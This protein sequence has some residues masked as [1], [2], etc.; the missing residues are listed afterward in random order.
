VKRGLLRLHPLD[1]FLDPIEGALVC[2]RRRQALVMLDLA[3]EFDALVTHGN[4]RSDCGATLIGCLFKTMKWKNCSLGT[5]NFPATDTYLFLRHHSPVFDL[6]RNGLTAGLLCGIQAF[7]E[8]LAAPKLN[9]IFFNKAFGL[10]DSF[11]IVSANERFESYEMP[12]GPDDVR[13][14]IS[15]LK[16]HYR[17]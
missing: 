14:V 6:V 13:A 15:H 11:A 9:W 12:V 1:Q 8:P 4:L 10:F 2:N 3:V 17:M 16:S 5:V 7:N